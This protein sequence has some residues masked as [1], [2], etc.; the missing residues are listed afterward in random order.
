LRGFTFNGRVTTL[1]PNLR[2]RLTRSDH[3]YIGCK[4]IYDATAFPKCNST[5]NSHTYEEMKVN[6]FIRF[7]KAV[8]IDPDLRKLKKNIPK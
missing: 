1:T 2:R 7:N 5:R 3:F 4:L 6:Y 8:L